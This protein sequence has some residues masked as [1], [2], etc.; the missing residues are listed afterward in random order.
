MEPLS[1]G[2]FVILEVFSQFK[3]FVNCWTKYQYNHTDYLNKGSELIT[4]FL[5]EFYKINYQEGKNRKYLSLIN[6]SK[7][8]NAHNSDDY[9]RSVNKYRKGVCNLLLHQHRSLYNLKYKNRK[10]EVIWSVT[11]H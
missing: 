7:F 10:D 6:L 11:F 8:C 5:F 1:D 2:F 3:D 4:V 9:F